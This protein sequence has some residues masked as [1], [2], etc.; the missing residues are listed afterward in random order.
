MRTA[1]WRVGYPNGVSFFKL[2]DDGDSDDD[3]EEAMAP[4]F[5]RRYRN[6]EL[7]TH[8]P[9]KH[10]LYHLGPA[11]F[12]GDNH[13]NL[14]LTTVNAGLWLSLTQKSC[15]RGTQEAENKDS[16]RQAGK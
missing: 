8:A 13:A 15:E 11:A 4:P 16:G 2:Q 12:L 3:V 5:S 10:L 6:F 14:T 7:H 1:L 9:I